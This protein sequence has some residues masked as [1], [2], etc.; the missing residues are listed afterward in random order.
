MEEAGVTKFEQPLVQSDRPKHALQPQ[1]G[2]VEPM[3][4]KRRAHW[5]EEARATPDEA[6]KRRA[7]QQ[8][9]GYKGGVHVTPLLRLS[10]GC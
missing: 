6:C 5:L 1:T 7:N 10:I 8:P 3:R 9:A 2:L 4:R